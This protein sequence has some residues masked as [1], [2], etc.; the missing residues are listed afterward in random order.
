MIIVQVNRNKIP[1][2]EAHRMFMKIKSI[3]DDVVIGTLDGISIMEL[4]LDDLIH[5][6]DNLSKM[7]EKLQKNF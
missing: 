6:R 4:E 7:I 3:T 1:P 5:Y 2:D